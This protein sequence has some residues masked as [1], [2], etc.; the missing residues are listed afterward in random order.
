M[1]VLVLPNS[2]Q[3]TAACSSCGSYSLKPVLRVLNSQH[4]DPAIAMSEA[5]VNAAHGTAALSYY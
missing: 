2:S 1:I 5:T 3:N 4:N